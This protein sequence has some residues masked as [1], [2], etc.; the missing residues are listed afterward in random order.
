MVAN[1][2]ANDDT[3]TAKASAGLNG[4][5]TSRWKLSADQRPKSSLHF[6]SAWGSFGTVGSSE[7]TSWKFLTDARRARPKKSRQNPWSRGLYSGARLLRFIELR[8]TR[9]ARGRLAKRFTA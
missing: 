3:A 9:I 5:F 2:V 6:C 1:F 7:S 8:R 4:C